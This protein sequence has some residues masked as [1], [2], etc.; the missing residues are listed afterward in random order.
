MDAVCS[1][2]LEG[3]PSY[4]RHIAVGDPAREILKKVEKEKIDMIV[5]S[6]QGA[7]AHFR[8][9]SVAEKVIKHAPV[10][11]VTILPARK[12]APAA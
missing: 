8:L 11:V 9:G 3:C 6:A 10:P 4:V 12:T 7:K 2:H 1:E 5:I